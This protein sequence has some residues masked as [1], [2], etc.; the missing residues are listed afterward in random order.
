[1]NTY[2][3]AHYANADLCHASTARVPLLRPYGVIMP[4][5]QTHRSED[6]DSL[7]A[8]LSACYQNSLENPSKRLPIT[9]YLVAAA[10]LW[11]FSQFQ[12]VV[13]LGYWPCFVEREV[14]LDEVMQI[15][16][17]YHGFK[18]VPITSLNN[19]PHCVWSPIENLIF[20]FVH[21][22]S[23][24]SI[25][26]PSTFEGELAVTLQTLTSTVR[27]NDTLARFLASE[28]VGQAAYTI[29]HGEFPSQVI[30]SGIL[31]LI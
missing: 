19:S 4:T 16:S 21:D 14:P 18:C 26:A 31:D 27:E 6:D 24:Y 20:R 1:M 9:P 29:V 10:R 11:L 5:S 15:F 13:N 3:R 30:A 8:R 23:H 12:E 28:I 7:C 22:Y 25:N 17:G 2:T